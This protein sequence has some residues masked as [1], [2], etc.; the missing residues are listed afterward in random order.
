VLKALDSPNLNVSGLKGTV[1]QLIA[2]LGIKPENQACRITAD[3]PPS[4][5]QGN[6]SIRFAMV[7]GC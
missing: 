5:N 7:K 2:H 6:F 1:A 3:K 4:D